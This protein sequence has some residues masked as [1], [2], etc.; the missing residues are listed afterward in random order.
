MRTMTAH[1]TTRLKN[2][3]LDKLAGATFR[4]RN[5]T[6]GAVGELVTKQGRFWGSSK[7]RLPGYFRYR[8]PDSSLAVSEARH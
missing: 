8:M 6:Y 4:P 1:P 3:V 5:L 2:T 7:S